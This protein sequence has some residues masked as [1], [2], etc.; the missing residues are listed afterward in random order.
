M[1]D[2]YTDEIG[3][4]G[5]NNGE[6]DVFP[7]LADVPPSVKYIRDDIHEA[8]KAEWDALKEQLDRKSTA[9]TERMIAVR[10]L[11][12]KSGLNYGVKKDDNES[13]DD[14]WRNVVYIDLPEGQVSWH[15]APHDLHLF[16]DFPQYTGKWDVGCNGK[17]VSFAKSI[18]PKALKGGE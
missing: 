6:Y 14:D 18:K 9:Y 4:G 15:I 7:D 2:M 17:S 13:W 5:Y 1:S 11:V 8:V 16:D 12:L 3:V 10:L